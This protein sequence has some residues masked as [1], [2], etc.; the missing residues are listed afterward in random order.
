[1]FPDPSCGCRGAQ[2]RH[3]RQYFAHTEAEHSYCL[4]IIYPG[5]VLHAYHIQPYLPAFIPHEEMKVALLSCLLPFSRCVKS[6]LF[7]SFLIIEP[8][9]CQPK[10]STGFELARTASRIALTFIPLVWIKYIK[11]RKVIKTGSFH[12]VPT[13]EED[14]VRYLKW[15]R[16][17]RVVLR[18]LLS[19]PFV[20]FWATIIASLE[21]TPLTGRCVSFLIDINRQSWS[22]RCL[23]FAMFSIQMAY[24][25]S[26][27]RGRG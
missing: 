1:M 24:D 18:T 20:L 5:S 7:K 6:F 15:L 27:I 23:L 19:I 26:F 22:P 25:P 2:Y 3:R 17:G 16:N 10:T 11:V 4:G 12:G 13:T 8:R 21:R 14:K 9:D